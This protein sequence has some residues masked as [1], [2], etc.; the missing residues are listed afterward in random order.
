MG[1]LAAH[2]SR[3]VV[4]LAAALAIAVRPAAAET[5]ATPAIDPY[6]ED[7]VG[8]DPTRPRPELLLKYEHQNLS[9]R[10]PDSGNA[11]TLEGITRVPIDE[12]WAGRLRFE[13]PLVLTNAPSADEADAAWRFGAGNLLTEAAAIHYPNERWAVAAGGQLAFPTASYDVTGADAWLI[14]V[15][16][17][18]RSMLPE[19]SPDSFVAPQLV[20]AFDAGGSRGRDHVSE[21]R[22]QPTLHWAPTPSIFV[23]LFPS[24]DIVVDLDAPKDRGR[25]FLP[26]NALAGI[27]VTP[28]LV[29]TLELGLPVVKDYPVYDFKLVSSVG[30][31]FD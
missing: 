30:Y 22:I 20:Y 7:P 16:G 31:F 8:A 14:G 23:E 27:L 6:Y 25:W 3:N 12:R 10:S 5:A 1:G 2:L 17:L 9:G 28:K 4:A 15:G 19:I 21:L 26:L 29:A 13:M 11:F 18:A 24:G